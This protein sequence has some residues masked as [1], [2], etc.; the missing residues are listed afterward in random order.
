MTVSKK[1]FNTTGKCYP[2]EHYMVDIH[3]QL[4]NSKRWYHEATISA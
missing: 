3:N 4:S 2:S 1:H